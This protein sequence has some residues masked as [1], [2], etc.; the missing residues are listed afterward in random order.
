MSIQ[1]AYDNWSATYDE[2]RNLTRDLDESVTRNQ[3]THRRFGRILELGCGTGKNTE[4][5]A[6]I[7]DSVIAI[8]FSSGMIERA[9]ERVRS[10]NVSF[11][12]ADLSRTWPCAESSI[13]LAAAHLVLEHLQNL[14]SVFSEA[15][16]ILIPGGEFFV[17]ELHPYRQYLGR[18]ATFHHG[19]APVEIPA[20]QH[21][22][23]DFL[24]A[25]ET[26][27]LT[28]ISLREW[29]HEHDRGGLPRLISFRFEK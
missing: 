16:R 17:C 2:D 5:Y 8:D 13:D 22:V 14:D 24:T 3:P 12:E 21:H 9:R 19:D 25:A 4:F 20:F 23:S 6:Q 18:K 7:G 28:M 11:L 27:G 10:R 29:W 15:A 1:R 26:N